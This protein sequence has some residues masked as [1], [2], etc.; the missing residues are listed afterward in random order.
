M[1]TRNLLFVQ[2]DQLNATVLSCYGGPVDTPNI[3]RIA[4]RGT[5]FDGATCP[6]P[7]CSP[8]RA[9]MVTGQY[10]H[11]HGITHNVMRRDYPAVDAPATEEG[12]TADDDTLGRLLGEQGYDTHHYGK[13][14]L[15]DDDLPHYP[16]MYREHHEYAAEMADRFAAVRE[17]PRE[18][19]MDWYGWA[20]PVE[21]DRQYA[22]AVAAADWSDTPGH[23]EFLRK[24]G[25]LAFDTD[26]TFDARV[27]DQTVER[28]AVA[29]EPFAVTAS[30]NM[31]HDPNVVP[32]PYYEAF[33]PSDLAL[34]D[35]EAREARFSE[36]W[37]RDYVTRVGER[38]LREF[39]RVYYAMVKLVDDQ[40]G[41]LL[42]AL[43]E[44][45]AREDTVVVF[46]ADHGDMCGGHGMVWK[47]TAAFYEEVLRVPLLI[48]APGH[49]AATA[50]AAGLVD[51]PPTVCDLLG[52][53]QPAGVQGR[54]LV[55]ALDGETVRRYTFAER[56]DSHPDRVRE[57]PTEPEGAFAV[58]DHE[59]GL[60][61]ARYP[62]GDEFLYDVTAGETENLVDDP[63]HADHRERLA[64]E[65]AAW[66]DRTGW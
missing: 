53:E 50:G 47:S 41:R 31:P 48:D 13:W 59:T 28:L 20:L 38:G 43:V 16:D 42:D 18:E 36:E 12:I 27:A 52:V 54:S 21:R 11:A 57:R 5:R 56:A 45:G 2:A 30:F 3:D 61:Y 9:S 35:N 40:V 60:K 19:W 22:E 39:L 51:L 58:R 64:A 29:E 26:E 33:D 24:M 32:E 17:R 4:E 6:T 66:Q 46:T 34:P 1:P 7:F 14:H 44:R 55:P 65:L 23:D 49:D 15:L 8:S 63:A 37:S 62:D 25:R 10:P